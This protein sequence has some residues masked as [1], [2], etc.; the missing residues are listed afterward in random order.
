MSIED[1]LVETGN[2]LIVFSI[3]EVIEHCIDN[4]SNIIKKTAL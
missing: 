1:L 3:A 2:L 4:S